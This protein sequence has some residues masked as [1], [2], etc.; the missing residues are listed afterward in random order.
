VLAAGT[1]GLRA[2]D[3]KAAQNIIART[4]FAVVRNQPTQQVGGEF[5]QKWGGAR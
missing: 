5:P 3:D 4:F 2:R 1:L